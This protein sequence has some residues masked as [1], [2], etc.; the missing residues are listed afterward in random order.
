MSGYDIKQR[1]KRLGWLI[2]SP[3]FGSLYPILRTLLEEGLV[4]VEVVPGFDRPPRKIYSVTEAGKAALRGWLDQGVEPGASLKAFVM[5]LFLA[6]N[7]PRASLLA[8]LAQRRRQVAAHHKDLVQTAQ[9]TGQELSLGQTLTLDYGL[10]LSTAELAWLDQ[11]LD[12]LSIQPP[13]QEASE[14]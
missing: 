13:P 14:H 9:G 12:R 1:L 8:D 2:D 6:G 5:R 4:T 10:A 3:S 7:L 11:T